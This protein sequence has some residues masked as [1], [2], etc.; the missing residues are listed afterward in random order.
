MLSSAGSQRPDFRVV[1]IKQRAGDAL[2]TGGK[3]IG[4]TDGLKGEG[5]I[6]PLWQHR[7]ARFGS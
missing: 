3:V 7:R 1:M 6:Q 2:R 4:K 5:N